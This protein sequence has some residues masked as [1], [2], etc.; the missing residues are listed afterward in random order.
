MKTAYQLIDSGDFLKLE[1]VGPFRIVRPSASAVWEPSLGKKEWSQ[2]DA[3]FKRFS[4][5]NGE[6][7]VRNAK[8]KEPWVI[9]VHGV[10][11]NLKLTGF[12]HLG[13]FAEQQKNWLQMREI[14]SAR[15]KSGRSVNVLNLF[16]YTGGSTLFT[17]AAGAEVTHLDAS[18]SSV[19][20]A[21]D[22]AKSSGLD[23]KPIR[24]I[25]DDVQEF[26]KKEIRREKKYQGIILDPPSYG[27]GSKNQIWKIEKDLIPLLKDL[28]QLMADDFLFILL[29]GHSPGYTPI[30]F[31]NQLRQI[32]QSQIAKSSAGPSAARAVFESGEMLI[33]DQQNLAL[34][35]GTYSLMRVDESHEY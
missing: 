17:A 23:G 18:K 11:F 14:V 12:G 21:R 10:K 3:E 35:S 1:Q 25:I 26:V 31:E 22:N 20:W 7:Q 24:W 9:D 30:S 19:A 28:R 13:I 8:I 15:V 29:S 6:W 16:A 34:P 5:G 4:D 27:R 33:H 32:F 2:F